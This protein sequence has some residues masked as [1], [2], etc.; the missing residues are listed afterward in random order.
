MQREHEER[1]HPPSD[2]EEGLAQRSDQARVS[3]PQDAG[4]D[5]EAQHL[6]QQQK[7]EHDQAHDRPAGRQD[8]PRDVLVGE[9]A[10]DPTARPRT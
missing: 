2:D 5:G 9:R 7:A 4:H 10:S 8:E 3:G 6:A 1:P